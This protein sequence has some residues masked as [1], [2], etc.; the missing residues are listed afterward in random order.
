MVVKISKL[1]EHTCSSTSKVKG[2]E[3]SIAWISQKVKDVVK[4]DPTL[5][6]TKLQKRLERHYNIQLSYFKVWSG[7]KSPMEDLH[8]T[9]EESFEM[10][11]RFKAA[12]EESCPGSIV[13]IDCKKINGKMHFSRMFVAIRACV[14]GFLA[15]CRPCG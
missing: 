7:R 4:E 12:L 9:W 6:A 10:L 5:G 14:D 1:D 2:R 8:G 3:A 13:E 15:G 11:C